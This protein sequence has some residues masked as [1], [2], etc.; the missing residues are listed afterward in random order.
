MQEQQKS[1]H[2]LLRV[3]VLALAL[4][5]GVLL[6]EFRNFSAPIAILTS[7]VLSISGV[8]LA[9]LITQTE[10]Q[11]G[12]LHGA[13]HGHRHRGEERHPAAGRG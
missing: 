5:F 11:R 7:S 2:D 6:V 9:L 10:L 1:F 13:D 12:E 3:L 4:V 8:V